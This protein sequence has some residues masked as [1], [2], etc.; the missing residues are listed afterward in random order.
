MPEGEK[1]ENKMGVEFSLYTVYIYIFRKFHPCAK[2]S[3]IF[4]EHEEGG[5]E[6]N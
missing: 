5:G 6:S 3:Q 4:G 1:G 2:K